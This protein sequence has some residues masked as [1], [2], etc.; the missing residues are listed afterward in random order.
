MNEVLLNQILWFFCIA[1][2]LFAVAIAAIYSTKPYRKALNESIFGVLE[3]P[4]IKPKSQWSGWGDIISGYYKGYSVMVEWSVMGYWHGGLG[5]TEVAI[6]IR[7]PNIGSFHIYRENFSKLPIGL[8]VSSLS[9]NIALWDSF[10]EL[11]DF[12]KVYSENGFFVVYFFY[13]CRKPKIDECSD[14][15]KKA[16]QLTL[17]I[18]NVS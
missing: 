3:N 14:Q 4:E 17:N 18:F 1:A 6:K 12:C 13:S 11:K 9:Q 10:L 8:E 7:K 2:F 15:I 5:G 16:L